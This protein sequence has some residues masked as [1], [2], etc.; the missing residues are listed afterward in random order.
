METKAI[1]DWIKGLKEDDRQ[2]VIF[3]QWDIKNGMI[4][5][6]ISG[7]MRELAEALRSAAE[8][9]IDLARIVVAAANELTESCDCPE[10]RKNKIKNNININ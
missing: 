4:H 1:T 10:C 9:D 3:I 8:E 2:A 7:K 6:T 5:G